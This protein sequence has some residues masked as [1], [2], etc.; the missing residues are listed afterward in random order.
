MP[1]RQRS[2]RVVLADATR[3]RETGRAVRARVVRQGARFRAPGGHFGGAR[4]RVRRR[5]GR[6]AA[7]L[8]RG[9]YT[10]FNFMSDGDAA[11]HDFAIAGCGRRRQLGRGSRRPAQRNRL[12][13]CARHVARRL[14]RRTQAR[15]ELRQRHRGHDDSVRSRQRRTAR[16]LFFFSAPPKNDAGETLGS[17]PCYRPPWS[18]LVAV[19]R[20]PATCLGD[21]ARRYAGPAGRQATHGRQRQRG[22]DVPRRAASCSSARRTTGASAPS[23]RRT[24]IELW[25]AHSTRRERQPDDLSRARRQTVCCSRGRRHV[26][27]VRAALTSRIN[28]SDADGRRSAGHGRAEDWRTATAHVG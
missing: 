7:A 5:C 19:M 16:A 13:A 3:A 28:V 6:R 9:P 27:G 15:Q 4:G 8:Q 14:D 1:Q 10:P 18:R 24:A 12:H 21:D 25:S 23:T 17:L 26:A 2:R 22:P 20:T 11:A